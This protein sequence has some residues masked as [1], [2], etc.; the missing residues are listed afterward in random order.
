[1]DPVKPKISPEVGSKGNGWKMKK[2]DQIKFP[3]GKKKIGRVYK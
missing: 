1:M 3:Q 2:T